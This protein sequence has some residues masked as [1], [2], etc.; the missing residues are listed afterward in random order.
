[1]RRFVVKKLLSVLLCLLILFSASACN[2]ASPSHES[3]ESQVQT[4]APSAD[5]P[6][7]YPFISLQE[8]TTWKEPLVA[9]FETRFGYG[10]KEPSDCGIALMDLNFDN[11]PEV[12]LTYD[13]GSMGNVDVIVYD[14]FSGEQIGYLPEL[15]SHQKW[16]GLYL[17]VYAD[18]EGDYRI[19][20]QGAFRSGAEGY[21]SKSELSVNDECE[22]KLNMLF[23][24]VASE[25][26]VT[27]YYWGDRAVDQSEYEKQVEQF[28]ND[29]E[30]IKQTQVQRIDWQSFFEDAKG[31]SLS[32]RESYLALA[33]A[34]ICSNQQFIDFN[35]AF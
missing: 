7:S 27:D 14:L 18:P 5:A 15:P 28:E 30:E 25:G 17:C 34:L 24:T 26:V 11:V 32:Q 12:L 4:Q 22:F 23:G 1:M 10:D 8:R 35:K 20:N 2:E 29:Y 33:E 21:W 16:Y 6:V 3:N 13:G 9:F 19:L 31:G